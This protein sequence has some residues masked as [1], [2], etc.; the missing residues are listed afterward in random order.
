MQSFKPEILSSIIGDIYD[1]ALQPDGWTNALTRIN[2]AVGGAYATISLSD[3]Q[4]AQPRMAAHSPWD[5]V[6]LKILNEEYGIEG[7]PGLKEVAFGDVD[8]PRSTLDQMSEAE[9]Q[10]S[11]FYTDWVRPQGLRDGCVMKFVHTADRIGAMAF[12]THATRDIITA[13]ERRFMAL[14]S[15]HARRA[16]MI[17]DL[18]D[19]QRVQ[20]QQFQQALDRLSAAV[21]LVDAHSQLLYANERGEALL[22]SGLHMMKRAGKLAPANPAMAHALSDAIVRTQGTTED[23]GGRGIAIPVSAADQPQAVAYVLPLLNSETRSAFGPAVAAVFI[24]SVMT[25]APPPLSVLATLYDLT[26]SEARVM[27][28]VGTG[29]TIAAIAAGLGVS[30]NTVKTHLARVFSKT[31]AE[32][33]ADLVRIVA[34]LSP[35]AGA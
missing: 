11:K 17:G 6:M 29:Q 33:Q 19:H 28:Q 25:G 23:L 16:A 26:P 20:T 24:S 31:N 7:V 10:T 13:D 27:L 4:F 1:C 9:F 12:I 21:F 5:P 35:T 30:E 8:T 15:P 34:A 22:S 18:L 14:I 3:P 2:A 32:R